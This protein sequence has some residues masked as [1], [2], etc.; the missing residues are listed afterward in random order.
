MVSWRLKR[1]NESILFTVRQFLGGEGGGGPWS[2]PKFRANS[3]LHSIHSIHCHFQQHTSTAV[4]TISSHQGLLDLFQLAFPIH[5]I[6]W[7]CSHHP[8][9]I[10][11]LAAPTAQGQLS[12]PP[13]PPLRSDA[14]HMKHHN[15]PRSMPTRS[16]PTSQGRKKTYARLSW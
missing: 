7:L 9:R 11:L 14:P 16:L 5:A 15:A 6:A 1:I 13:A 2:S 10:T 3:W 12:R 8:H 4:T